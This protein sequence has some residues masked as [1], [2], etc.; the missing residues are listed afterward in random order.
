M[1]RGV[2]REFLQAAVVY[3]SDSETDDWDR[4]DVYWRCIQDAKASKPNEIAQTAM[5]FL[6][7]WGRMGRTFPGNNHDDAIFQLAEWLYAHRSEIG[8]LQRIKLKAANLEALAPRLCSLYYGLRW[9]PQSPA[10]RRYR[11]FGPT[12]AGKIL[13]LLLPDLCLIWDARYIREPLDLDE[14]AWS[15]WCY[16]R[17]TQELLRGI[18]NSVCRAERVSQRDG[19]SRLQKQHRETCS[20]ESQKWHE[21]PI[22]KI[23][24]EANY[25]T[26]DRTGF[27]FQRR[28]LRPILDRAT[29]GR[30]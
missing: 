30:L 22:L 21:E 2:D 9:L 6:L 25:Q 13:H 17:A 24:D 10:T 8:L 20:P 19:L 7:N 18:V 26:P 27:S 11:S 29:E 14:D 16:L 3:H 4:E 5:T 23:L 15:Y 28:Y 12:S 1:R